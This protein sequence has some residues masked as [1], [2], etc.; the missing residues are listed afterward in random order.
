MMRVYTHNEI[1]QGSPAWFEVRKGIPTSS[2]FF[3][4]MAK[5]GPRGGTT[6]KEFMQRTNYMRM[7]AGEIVTN[8]PAEQEW[9]GNQ[10][11]ERGHEREDEARSMY[12]FLHDVEPVRVG[13]VRNGNCGCSPDSFVGTGGLEI[14]DALPHRQIERLQAGTLPSEH[15]WQVLGSL[16]VCEDREFWDFVSHCRGLPLLEVRVYRDKVTEELKE[17]REG[18]D[19]FVEETQQLVDWLRSLG[20]VKAAV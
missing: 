19:R 16:L 10:H 11:T 3:K 2:S 14:K 1:E 9:S 5:V 17:L 6:S 7:L 4:V 12:S 15:R 20:K 18:I 13:F 8:R